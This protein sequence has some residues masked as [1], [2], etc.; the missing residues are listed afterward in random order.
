MQKKELP[1]DLKKMANEHNKKLE[2]AS[3]VH[4]MFRLTQSGGVKKSFANLQIAIENDPG[5]KP[6]G[7]NEFRQILT[8]GE[9]REPIDD[10][11]I[12][13]VR[14]TIDK[15]HNVTF[16]KDDIFAMLV[17]VGKERRSYHPVKEMIES[18]KWDGKERANSIF[19]DYLG[20]ENNDYIREVARKWLVGG[21]ARIYNPGVKMEIVPVL[22]GKQGIGK[23]TLASRLGGEYFTDSLSSLGETKDDYQ[24][25]IGK[26]IIE[27][28]E[29]SSM[30][31]TDTDK[32]KN[33][34]SATSD[35]I[36]LPYDRIP[37]SH[38]RTSIFIGTTNND[39]YLTDLSGNRR[40]YPVPLEEEPEKSVHDISDAEVQQIW[41]EA[42]VY[43]DAGEELFM[44]ELHEIIA[45][46][47]RN[48]AG[49]EDLFFADI[50]E[51]V[52]M[53]VPFDWE[54]MK[55]FEKR[56]YFYRYLHDND[57]SRGTEP[58]DKTTSK[59]IARVVFDLDGKGRG[60]AGVLNKINLYMSNL[61]GWK[62]QSVRIDG[63]VM[64]GFKR[65]T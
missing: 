55:L 38:K 21:I 3:K 2:K 7:Y 12:Q 40:F 27:L 8:F 25:L 65:V 11:F 45:N 63:K 26:W 15:Q 49:K 51:F 4:S 46:E 50:E 52:D 41:A 17:L 61:P 31:K 18:V 23:S 6:L 9:D 13:S 43:Y 47:Y 59:Q 62:K 60:S 19:I 42:K 20:A 64:K 35:D 37:K 14:L 53:K 48:Q 16:T 44:D 10:S 57:T 22:S 1:D 34:L 36:R 24:Q 30:K 32:I 29:L 39:E 58:I 54:N 5:L 28:G 56:N 33:F